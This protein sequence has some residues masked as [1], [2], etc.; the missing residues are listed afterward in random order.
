MKVDVEKFRETGLPRNDLFFRDTEKC[1]AKVCRWFKIPKEKK[2]LLYAPTFRGNFLN[3]TE[4]KRFDYTVVQKA[5]EKKFGQEFAVLERKHHAVRSKGSKGVYPASE[6]P[7]MQE[8]LAAADVLIT[9]Y[10]SCMWD[11]A[12]TDKP[13]FLFFPDLDQ[14]DREKDFYTSPEQWPYALAKTEEELCRRIE[15][16]ERET[17]LKKR[18]D[19]ME[20]AKN[21]ER[22]TASEQLMELLGIEKRA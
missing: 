15:E 1:R 13:G 5:L 21:C 9:D 2:L 12:L 18:D 6:Y 11:F 19:F 3:A 20:L 16:Y 10:S 8:L 22:G 4:V 14:F 17:A 7:D